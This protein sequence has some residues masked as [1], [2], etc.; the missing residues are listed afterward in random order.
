[1][2]TGLNTFYTLGKNL[3]MLTNF[4]MDKA[5]SEPLMVKP[6]KLS[7]D[8]HQPD[9]QLRVSLYLKPTRPVYSSYDHTAYCYAEIAVSF[10]CDGRD[11]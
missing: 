11:H 1:M 5:H 10:S 9:S 7:Y 3:R 8:P 4:I 6:I 2:E